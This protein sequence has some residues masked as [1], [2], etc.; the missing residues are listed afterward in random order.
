MVLGWW[1]GWWCWLAPGVGRITRAAPQCIRRHALWDRP[2]QV[3]SYNH[4]DWGLVIVGGNTGNRLGRRPHGGSPHLGPHGGNHG[5]HGPHGV[6]WRKLGNGRATGTPRRLGGVFPERLRLVGVDR[7][8]GEGWGCRVW[9]LLIRLRRQGNISRGH[10][11]WQ[12]PHG[13]WRTQCCR[14]PWPNSRRGRS[15]C[16]LASGRGIGP[17]PRTL[18]RAP[19]GKMPGSVAPKTKGGRSGPRGGTPRL[20]SVH[21]RCLPHHSS[22]HLLQQPHAAATGSARRHSPGRGRVVVGMAGLAAQG[23]QISPLPSREKKC[24]LKRKNTIPHLGYHPP[25]HHKG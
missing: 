15:S 13:S 3:P 24:K 12:D 10:T 5:L 21:S 20:W 1:L 22:P 19:P 23:D 11:P 7:S 25:P 8:L 6:G 16:P 4:L 18:P 14:R 17:A 2:S 9:H